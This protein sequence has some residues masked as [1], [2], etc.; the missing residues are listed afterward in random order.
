MTVK[1]N[2]M[3]KVVTR[4]YSLEVKKDDDGIFTT[5]PKLNTSDKIKWVKLLSY[6]G[7]STNENFV[8]IFGKRIN[9]GKNEEV[10]IKRTVFRADK[11]ENFLF[12]DKVVK[13]IEK[14][15]DEYEATFGRHMREYNKQE[16]EKDEQ[17]LL[18]CKVHN[19]DIEETDVDELRKV[20]EVKNEAVESKRDGLAR[21]GIVYSQTIKSNPHTHTMGLHTH[22]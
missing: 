10:M 2:V 4:T 1:N 5:R 14:A 8:H 6:N 18:Y 11:N 7:A 22:Q 20:V 3:G 9:I 13:I 17:L 19:L 16:I 12:S 15:K 21:G